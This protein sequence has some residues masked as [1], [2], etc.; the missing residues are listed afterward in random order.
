MAG[1]RLDGF[2][3]FFRCR[4]FIAARWLL[5]FRLTFPASTRTSLARRSLVARDFVTI[6]RLVAIRSGLRCIVK[7][8]IVDP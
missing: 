6:D 1:N 2:T 8:K 7:F 3:I 4:F 5:T